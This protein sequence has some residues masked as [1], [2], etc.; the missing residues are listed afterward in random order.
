[1]CKSSK[2]QNKYYTPRISSLCIRLLYCNYQ[3]NLHYLFICIIYV[4][5]IHNN[6]DF[7]PLTSLSSNIDRA[8]FSQTDAYSVSGVISGRDTAYRATTAC[9]NSRLLTCTQTYSHSHSAFILRFYSLP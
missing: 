5:V 4:N 6:F 9:S 2:P 8:H 3:E 7:S 1:M